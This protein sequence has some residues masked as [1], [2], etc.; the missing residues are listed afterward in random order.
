MG[1]RFKIKVLFILLEILILYLIVLIIASCE[2]PLRLADNRT[3]GLLGFT[4]CSDSSI[5]SSCSSACV[6]SNYDK[7]II[8]N[9]EYLPPSTKGSPQ[10]LPE[11]VD[12]EKLPSSSVEIGGS[13]RGGCSGCGGGR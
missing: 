13:S 7:E 11:L 5:A 3:T 6:S 9:I 4:S 8:P 1:A 10:K 2:S 12:G